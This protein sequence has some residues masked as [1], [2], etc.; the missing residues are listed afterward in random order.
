VSLTPRPHELQFQCSFDLKGFW[1]QDFT[2]ANQ[3]A[4]PF[5]PPTSELP[6]HSTS[7]DKD[8]FPPASLPNLHF[9]AATLRQLESLEKQRLSVGAGGNEGAAVCTEPHPSDPALPLPRLGQSQEI[10]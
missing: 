1:I 10:L 4:P 9:S 5:E 8:G 7:P 3:P 6:P 2:Q